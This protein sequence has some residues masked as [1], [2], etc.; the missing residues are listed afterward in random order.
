MGAIFAW[1]T[2]RAQ[3]RSRQESIKVLRGHKKSTGKIE[4]IIK[5]FKLDDAKEALTGSIGDCKVFVS[6]I[7][8]AVLHP[9][10]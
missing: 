3:E 5:P 4:A 1:A 10:G 6:P 8:G 2:G 7:E 9:H